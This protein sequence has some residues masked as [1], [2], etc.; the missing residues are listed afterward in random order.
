MAEPG[1]ALDL[2][3]LRAQMAQYKGATKSISQRVSL[4]ASPHEVYT[5]LLDSNRHASAVGKPTKI[6]PHVGGAVSLN[7]GQASG[8][9]TELLDDQHIVIAWRP[10]DERWPA[11]HYS[12]ATFMM[13]PEGKGTTLV[14]FQQGVPEELA[15][16]VADQ[17][18]HTYWDKLSQAFSAS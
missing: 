17:W 5:T 12:T 4:A 9:I 7:G 2:R 8:I 3:A 10:A 18:Q 16:E 14:F 15:D 1:Q 6:E 11:D 13:R